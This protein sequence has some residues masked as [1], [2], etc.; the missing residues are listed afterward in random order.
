MN[1]EMVKLLLSYTHSIKDILLVANDQTIPPSSRLEIIKNIALENQAQEKRFCK[2]GTS[3]K[4][5]D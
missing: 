5:K 3:G 1:D 2:G 4:P